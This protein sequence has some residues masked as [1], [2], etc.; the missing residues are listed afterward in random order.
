MKLSES[1]NAYIS[2]RISEVFD[3]ADEESKKELEAVKELSLKIDGELG[4]VHE[5]TTTETK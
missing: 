3:P 4:I 5:D 2:D 1:I